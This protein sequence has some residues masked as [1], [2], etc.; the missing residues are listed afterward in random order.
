MI[1][2]SNCSQEFDESD[3]IELKG[4]FICT[5]CKP[6]FLQK[7]EEGV[8]HLGGEWFQDKNKFLVTIHDSV[9][10][11][12]CIKCNSTEIY[13]TQKLKKTHINPFYI[14][15]IFIHFLILLVVYFVVRKKVKVEISL[16]IMHYKKKMMYLYILWLLFFLTIGS[17][18]FAIQ[19][20]IK[21]VGFLAGF[22]LLLTLIFYFLVAGFIS[23]KKWTK[24]HVWYRGFSK[25]FL[26]NLAEWK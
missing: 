1:K 26:S 22:F 10:P 7:I 13:K 23:V 4:H 24:T 17:G 3:V 5:E 2:C 6:V 12:R 15:L 9:L 16:C 19:Y 21:Y 14:L 11:Q 25:S 8:A 20:E 18:F